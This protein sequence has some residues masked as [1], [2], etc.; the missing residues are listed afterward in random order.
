MGDLGQITHLSFDLRDEES[1][2][3]CVRNSDTVY[4]LIGRDYQTKNFSYDQVLALFRLIARSTMKARKES[5]EYVL[6]KV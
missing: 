5:Q 4:N 1:L 3:E 2:R 6:K